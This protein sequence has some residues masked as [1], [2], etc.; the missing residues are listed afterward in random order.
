MSKNRNLG[1]KTAILLI[2]A[3]LLPFLAIMLC[4]DL[5][6]IPF[7]W[8]AGLQLASHWK[9]TILWWNI[10]KRIGDI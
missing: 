3:F 6:S 7:C 4:I 8:L 5:L 1:M 2:Q 9:V 10:I